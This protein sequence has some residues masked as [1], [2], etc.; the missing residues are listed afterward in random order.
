MSIQEL[1][2]SSSAT[3]QSKK[4]QTLTTSVLERLRSDIIKGRLLP[5]QRLRF[6]ELKSTYGVGLSPLREALMRLVA[7]GLDVFVE[8]VE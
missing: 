5:A 4:E 7:D 8:R 3:R 2:N 6:E 1:K